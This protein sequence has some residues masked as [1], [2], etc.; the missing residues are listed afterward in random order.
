MPDIVSLKPN[1]SR[2]Q[3]I[4][5]FDSI[6]SRVLFGPL[7]SIADVYIPFLLFDVE[8]RNGRTCERRTYGVDAVSGDLDAYGFARP[9]AVADLVS[10]TTRNCVPSRMEEEPAWRKL[11]EKLRRMLYR[12]GFFRIRQLEM[13]PSA[14]GQVWVPYWVGFRGSEERA[15][16]TV[17]DAVRRRPEGAKIRTL[18]QQWL[19]EVPGASE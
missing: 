13:K 7:R 5:Q 4:R 8:I 9:P 16:L 15:T 11:E 1:V 2:E 10:M 6:P 17:L 19:C 12:S 18:L 14:Q 3:A